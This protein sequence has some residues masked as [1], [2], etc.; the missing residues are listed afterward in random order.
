MAEPVDPDALPSLTLAPIIGGDGDDV[1]AAVA[2]WESA[3]GQEATPE[4]RA[5]MKA[6]HERN[7]QDRKP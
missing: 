3:T 1:D 4:I 5:R 7:R 2:V 6:R